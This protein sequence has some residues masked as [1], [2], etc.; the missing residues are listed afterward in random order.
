MIKMKLKLSN[1][2]SLNTICRNSK[3]C[4]QKPPPPRQS[5][6]M[7]PT[8]VVIGTILMN[9]KVV[10]GIMAMIMSAACIS[11]GMI[12]KCFSIPPTDLELYIPTIELHICHC[13]AT[14]N[15]YFFPFRYLLFI[16]DLNRH[17][18]KCEL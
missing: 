12:G 5:L 9:Q 2:L 7:G 16:S 11:A 13:P 18:C 10:Y 1:S 8:M 6:G 15:P 3:I 17:Y 14:S 4:R